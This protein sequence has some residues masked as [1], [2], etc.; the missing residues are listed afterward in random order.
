[1]TE[2][3]P[4]SSLD[5]VFDEAEAQLSEKDCII[6]EKDLQ[7]LDL[8]NRVDQY[9][10]I[11]EGCLSYKELIQK[12]EEQ[13][14]TIA[15][16]DARMHSIVEQN[17]LLRRKIADLEKELIPTQSALPNVPGTLPHRGKIRL[18]K[19]RSVSVESNV[20]VTERAGSVESNHSLNSRART[21]AD[22]SFAGDNSFLQDEKR[23]ALP[24][25]TE[26]Q[27]G[28]RAVSTTHPGRTS[29]HPSTKQ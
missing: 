4:S 3:Q 10:N 27:R 13:S 18:C 2:D 21:I 5:E 7:I 19:E 24:A 23:R 14:S 1:M 20:Q 11:G 12:L 6:A 15:E 17:G 26:A 8:K 16:L 25:R 9:E 29:A 22:T 28:T